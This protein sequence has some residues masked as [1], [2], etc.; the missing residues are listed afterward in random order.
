MEFELWIKIIKE[1][2]DK[3]NIE[4]WNINIADIADEYLKTIKELRR[5]DIRL[6]ADVI[7]VG[8]IL[9]R[10]KSQILYGECENTLNN[11]E[12]INDNFDYDD[13]YYDMH[14]NNEDETCIKKSNMNNTEEYKKNKKNKNEINKNKQ[15]NITFNDLINTLK[16]ELDKVKKSASGKR[17]YK[18]EIPV[19]DIIE[20][21][22]E[23]YDISD[24]MEHIVQELRKEGDFIFQ[25]KF[26]TRKDIVKNLLPSLYLANDG[27]IEI[28]QEEIF[29]EIVLKYKNQ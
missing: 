13:D 22:E 15:K 26:S 11:E 21:M 8:G 23:D 2:I 17:K 5:F 18:K 24:L 6:S 7:L 10:M 19:Y 3:K 28:Y 14:S 20:E 25:N 12:N 16:C 27:K 29:K 9:L 1:S 4:P